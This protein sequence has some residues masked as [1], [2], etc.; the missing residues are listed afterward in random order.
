LKGVASPHPTGT[1]PFI[2]L[3]GA[4]V[5]GDRPRFRRFIKNQPGLSPRPGR[6][7]PQGDRPRFA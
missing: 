6:K 5:Q 1:T 7:K 2:R 4:L 3:E